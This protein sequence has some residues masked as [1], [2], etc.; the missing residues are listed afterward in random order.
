M[1]PYPLLILLIGLGLGACNLP[2]APQTSAPQTVCDPNGGGESIFGYV[3][4]C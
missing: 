4:P 1:K 3:P 2:T